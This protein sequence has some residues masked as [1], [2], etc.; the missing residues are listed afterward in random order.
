MDSIIFAE[1]IMS[2]IGLVD[3]LYNSFAQTD[4]YREQIQYYGYD[5]ED[6]KDALLLNYNLFNTTSDNLMKILD[7]IGEDLKIS[8]DKAFLDNEMCEVLTN[9]SNMKEHL[10]DVPKLLIIN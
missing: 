9:I 3:M 10:K 5:D 2:S 6:T 4:Y 1:S 7:L 8:D